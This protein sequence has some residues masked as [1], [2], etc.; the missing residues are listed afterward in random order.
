MDFIHSR[1]YL[2]EGNVAQVDC[3]LQCNI[4]LMDDH[5]F[6]R[7]Q[8]CDQYQYYGGFFECFPAHIEAPHSGYWNIVIDLGGNQA[9]I[10]CDIRFLTNC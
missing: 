4:L 1:D 9:T 6:R 3:S 2:R 5:N 8:N 7:Y 10:K